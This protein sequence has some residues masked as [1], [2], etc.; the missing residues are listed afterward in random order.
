MDTFL[1][2]PCPARPGRGHY[3]APPDLLGILAD[4]CR[5]CGKRVELVPQTLALVEPDKHQEDDLIEPRMITG[6]GPQGSPFERGRGTLTEPQK[7]SLLNHV[8]F[9]K[10]Y[11][12]EE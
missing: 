12:R 6:K 7:V 10:L 8:E 11:G 4:Q 3:P 2:G 1:D 9:N 5:D